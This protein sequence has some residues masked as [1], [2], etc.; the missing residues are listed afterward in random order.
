MQLDQDSA[1]DTHNQGDGV[2]LFLAGDVMIGRGIDQLS[3]WHCDPL[4]H[5]ASVKDAREY[6]QLI[7]S[8]QKRMK[9]EN[10]QETGD[11]AQLIATARAQWPTYVWG[12]ALT[13]LSHLRPHFSLVNLETALT[14]RSATPW[15]R[16]AVHYHSHP[17]N[18]HL[19][20][21]AG[22]EVAC[23]ANNHSLDW[24]AEGF[25]DTLQTLWQA[26]I[27]AAG[28]RDAAAVAATN[29]YSMNASSSSG[30]S[31]S[32]VQVKV[33][34][35]ATWSSGVPN[36]WDSFINVIP[37]RSSSDV[38]PAV[39]K[40][41][42]DNG[43]IQKQRGELWIASVHWGPNWYG[44]PP[45]EIERRFAQACIDAGFNLFHGHSS[46]HVRGL[47][48][49][50]GKLILYGCGDLITDYEG[51]H[52]HGGGD[53]SSS[54]AVLLRGDLGAMWFPTLDLNNGRLLALVAVP[55]TLR[56]FQLQR[57]SSTDVERLAELIN[58]LSPSDFQ[59]TGARMVAT[60]DHQQ[61]RL[62]LR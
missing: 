19:L 36:G 22:V 32:R 9:G 2:R 13:V 56:R 11:V 39:A 1:T 44:A 28:V 48:V 10:D 16:K 51:I 29:T 60:M 27:G 23:V 47:E 49:Y 14:C 42:K 52:V 57:P 35:A 61:L 37:L 12:F 45:S 6:L 53:M 55:T 62:I 8:E 41:K 38:L 25:A 5:E 31:K 58:I 15:P 3:P 40:L 18:V 26:G 30:W 43:F 54:S 46:H 21:V 33:A 4:L 34:A 50:R 20:T 17:E 24:G 59:E 7:F